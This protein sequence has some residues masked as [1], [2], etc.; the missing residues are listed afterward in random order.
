M[1]GLRLPWYRSSCTYVDTYCRLHVIRVG[2]VQAK[3]ANQSRLID[4]DVVDHED[5]EDE[6]SFPLPLPPLQTSLS[7]KQIVPWKSRTTFSALAL[8]H[9]LLLCSMSLSLCPSSG[10]TASAAGASHPPALQPLHVWTVK[11]HA[12][13]CGQF[14]PPQIS[15]GALVMPLNTVGAVKSLWYSLTSQADY[16]VAKIAAELTT[17][18]P[19]YASTLK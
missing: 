4:D 16:C 3:Q 17:H 5:D 6:L 19:S 13:P 12:R 10:V 8:N 18:R 7:I 15:V 2:A 11:L 14:S 9:P 1:C